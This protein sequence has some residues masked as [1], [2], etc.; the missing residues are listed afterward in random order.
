MVI[1]LSNFLGFLTLLLEGIFLQRRVFFHQPRLLGCLKQPL[2]D[3]QECFPCPLSLWCPRTCYP[4]LP[5]GVIRRAW[6]LF[7]EYYEPGGFPSCVFQSIALVHFDASMVLSS[8]RGSPQAPP[9]PLRAPYHDS[10]R[11]LQLTCVLVPEWAVLYGALV[12]L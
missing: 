4:W 9:V 1:F 7:C 11:L 8:P 12:P 10:V 2:L 5:P 3:D 6:V